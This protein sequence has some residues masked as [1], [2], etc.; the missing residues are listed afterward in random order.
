LG[1]ISEL[2]MTPI[3]IRRVNLS[4]QFEVFREPILEAMSDV[5]ASGIYMLGEQTRAFEEEFSAYLGGG[6]ECIAVADGTR[7]ISLTLSSMG[8]GSGDEVITTPFTAIPTIGAIMETGATPVFVDIDPATWLIDLGAVK[9]KLT[10]RTKAI[11]PVHMFGNVVDIPALKDIVGADV[12]ILEDAAQ[13]HGSE[14]RGMKAGTMADAGTFSF[15][16][17]KN[18]GAY[19][20]AGAI[21]TADKALAR[22]LRMLRN[23]GMSDKDTCLIPG[24]NSRLDEI[25]AAI[26]RVKLPRLDDMNAARKRLVDAYHQGLPEDRFIF[27]IIHGDVVSNHHIIQSRFMGNRDNLLRYMD[28]LGI[29]CNVYY[30]IPHHLQPALKHLGYEVGDLPVVE[31]LCREAIALPL[32]PE[33]SEEDVIEVIRACKAFGE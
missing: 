29:Q 16:P 7:A 19:G 26:L 5:L 31:Q 13:G 17:S 33:M 28:D 24:V 1:K 22:R 21:V 15:Y 20:D 18:L 25:Q 8:V 4:K 2:A 9:D 14:C 3:R 11:V 27:Q 6:I 10:E 30:A 23:H 12:K 32:Y